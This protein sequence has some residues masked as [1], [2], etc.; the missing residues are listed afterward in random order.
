MYKKCF[1]NSECST[2]IE[3]N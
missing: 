1:V 2:R 3:D